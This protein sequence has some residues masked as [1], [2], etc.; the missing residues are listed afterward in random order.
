VFALSSPRGS[1][2]REISVMHEEEP[3]W[4]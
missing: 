3:S 1:E 4:P 2:I